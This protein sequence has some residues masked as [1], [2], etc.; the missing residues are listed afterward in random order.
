M[1]LAKLR[2]Q[3][4]MLVAQAALVWADE[5]FDRQGFIENGQPKDAA[6]EIEPYDPLVRK[7]VVENLER[8]HGKKGHRS[9]ASQR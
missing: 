4:A 6:G 2:T 7:L 5:Q 1:V 9:G 8:Q 3:R